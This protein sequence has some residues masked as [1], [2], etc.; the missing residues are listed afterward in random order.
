MRTVIVTQGA[1]LAFV[2][3][4]KM[5]AL[6]NGGSQYQGTLIATAGGSP[7]GSYGY[8]AMASYTAFP[9]DMTGGPVQVAPPPHHLQTKD[10]Q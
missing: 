9:P 3:N 1:P 8:L 10:L 6:T 5:M 7:V 2:I 4:R